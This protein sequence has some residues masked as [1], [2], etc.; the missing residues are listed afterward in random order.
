M[1]GE[2]QKLT[3]IMHGNIQV[4]L[5]FMHGNHRC[6]ILTCPDI[7]TAY[8]QNCGKVMFSQVLSVH[9]GVGMGTHS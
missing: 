5:T 9:K 6:V 4:W 3:N 7:V 2:K 1:V 8:K